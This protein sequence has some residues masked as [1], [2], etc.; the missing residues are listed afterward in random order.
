MESEDVT[1]IEL[2][3]HTDPAARLHSADLV[4]QIYELLRSDIVSARIPQG[5]KLDETEIARKLGVSRNPVREAIRRLEGTG[6]LVDR[7]RRGRFVRIIDRNDVEDI[8]G[9]RLCMESYYATIAASKAT[10]EDAKELHE[11]LRRLYESAAR[12]DDEGYIEADVALHRGI[13]EISGSIRALRAFDT[14][15]TEVQMII[16]LLG[17]QSKAL[18]DAARLHEPIIDAIC[19]RDGNLASKLLAEHIISTKEE[20]L[21]RFAK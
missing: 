10:K 17:L 9:F 15:S 14:V 12:N 6:I 18:D 16:K 1:D 13:C 11:L 21:L 4:E 19:A 2:A 20:L 3:S 7:P 5:H 8:F